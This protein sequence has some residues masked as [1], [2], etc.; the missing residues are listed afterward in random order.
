[1]HLY[2]LQ[3]SKLTIYV[4]NQVLE[5]KGDSVEERKFQQNEGEEWCRLGFCL[6]RTFIKLGQIWQK[7][8]ELFWA[9]NCVKMG[10]NGS[11]PN[12]EI[13]GNI[14]LYVMHMKTYKNYK[15]MATLNYSKGQ[16]ITWH[17]QNPTNPPKSIIKSSKTNIKHLIVIN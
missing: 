12:T 2:V 9:W 7:G 10:P 5:E 3:W 16:N 11:G 4:T 1:M 13:E 8:L 17:G 14:M 6:I 15:H